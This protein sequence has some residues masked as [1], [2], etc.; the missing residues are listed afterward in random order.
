ML[1]GGILGTIANNIRAI[2]AGSLGQSVIDSI[3]T[4]I[5][6]VTGGI[7][8]LIDFENNISGSY[9][10]GGSQFGT[11]DS[12]CNTE[13]GVLHN[14]NS[15]GVAGNARMVAQLKGLYDRLSGYPVQ[16]SLGESTGTAGAGH[17]YDSNGNR[18]LQGEVIEYSNIF[19]L[20]LEQS[21]L[22]IIANDDNPTPNLPTCCA[23]APASA[24]KNSPALKASL[25]F[26]MA[27]N[28][29]PISAAP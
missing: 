25:I 10:S 6:S 23:I 21:L 29:P 22:D 5:N 8:S 7:S 4:D 3:R 24:P 11:P 28:A 20:L 12:G 18:I 9:T 1:N 14:P 26:A 16:Y 27:P 13:M 15:G 2:N 17:Q 19:Q